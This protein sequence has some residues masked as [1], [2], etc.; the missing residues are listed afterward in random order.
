M[1]ILVFFP[2]VIRGGC[3]EH[4]YIIIRA[5]VRAGHTVIACFPQVEGTRSIAEDV[6]AAG[7]CIVPW[8]LGEIV[9]G[10]ISLGSSEL[11]ESLAA[12][13]IERE[14][15][16]AVLVFLPEPDSS[17]GFIAACAAKD[18]PT[19]PVFCLVPQG[20]PVSEADRERCAYAMRRSQRWVAISNDNRRHLVTAF[21][22][23]SLDEVEIVYNGVDL[24]IEWRDPDRSAVG[25]ARDALRSELGIRASARVA[26]TVARL[27][28]PKGHGDLLAAIPRLPPSCEDVHFVWVGAGEEERRLRAGIC[29]SG[30]DGRVHLLGYRRDVAPLLH[31]ADVFVFP[32]HWEG[33]SRALIEAMSAELPIVASD[34]SSNPELVEDGRHGLLFPARDPGALADRLTYA[35]EHPRE[36][37]AMARRAR[38]RARLELTESMMCE[39]TL[40]VVDDI[41]GRSRVRRA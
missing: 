18:V 6:R 23:E 11:Q 17:I 13:L 9:D 36:M 27:A 33:C 20:W 34:A 16:D 26:L 12:P 25:A 7:A 21:G 35:L 15:P 10:R 40:R 31:A 30:L 14:N 2:G 8:P 28:F 4:S 37:L 29:H 19:V 24:P 22:I 32:T 38:G 3:E 5:A 39:G 41:A 1:R